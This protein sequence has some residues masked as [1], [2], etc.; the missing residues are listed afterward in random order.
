MI[1]SSL[2]PPEQ[3]A[4]AREPELSLRHLKWP[5]L[6]GGLAQWG[7]RLSADPPISPALSMR[8]IVYSRWHIFIEMYVSHP[9]SNLDSIFLSPH[10]P[11]SWGVSFHMSP[12]GATVGRCRGGG[13]ETRQGFSQAQRLV[14][15]TRAP[16]PINGKCYSQYLVPDA[17]WDMGVGWGGWASR[18]RCAGL[19]CLGPAHS[20]DTWPRWLPFHPSI[21][22]PLRV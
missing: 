18:S 15:H 8:C 20:Q 22:G 4:R 11:T 7:E 19:L 6:S 16:Q 5:F 9:F 21:R 3:G 10:F 12:T 13:G 1:P 14:S 2:P 17:F